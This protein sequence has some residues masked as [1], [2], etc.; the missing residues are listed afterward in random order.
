MLAGMSNAVIFSG[1]KPS[2]E[3]TL[4]NY[5][6]AL[7]RFPEYQAHGQVMLCVVDLHAITVRQDP[8]ALRERTRKIAAWYLACGID[9]DQTILFVQSHVPA[10]TQLMWALNCFTQM[11]ELSRQTQFK[12]KSQKGEIAVSAGLFNYP[13]LMAADILLYGTPQVP[14]G[15]DQKQHVELA[16]DIAQR[17]NGVYGPTLVIPEPII[18]LE[19]ARVMDL[20][21]PLKKMSKSESGLGC[22][23]LL[24]PVAEIEKKIKRAVTD[25]LNQVRYDKVNQPGV[26]NLLSIY[27]ACTGQTVA[28]A[29]AALEQLQ[30]GALKAAVAEAVVTEL[31]PVQERFQALMAAPGRVDA[32]LAAG[33][34]RAQALA[35]PRLQAVYEKIGFLMPV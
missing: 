34:L 17:F 2:G 7:R 19:G 5:L 30:Y 6:G 32:I 10:H 12:D 1:I 8:A 28:A 33:A 26:A 25:T 18:P 29:T 35:A 3:M 15:E 22:I 14:V 20:Q 9:P 16:R 23:D 21:D 27:A 11:G 31:R 4:G 24:E 13:V